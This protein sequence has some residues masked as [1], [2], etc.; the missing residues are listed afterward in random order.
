MK[1]TG[2]GCP[3]CRRENVKNGLAYSISWDSKV[4]ERGNLD[5][6]QISAKEGAHGMAG[7]GSVPGRADRISETDG[8]G[9]GGSRDAHRTSAD[10]ASEVSESSGADEK[11]ERSGPLK[12]S[13]NPRRRICGF[14]LFHEFVGY[15]NRQKQDRK[16][17]P[18]TLRV[19][20]DQPFKRAFLFG[21]IAV[22]DVAPVARVAAGMRFSFLVR[23][24]NHLLYLV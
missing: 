17:E 13:A 12:K 24:S 23:Q 22:I 7:S 5:T 14:L 15:D 6:G 3:P 1:E 9:H 16:E 4:Y 10:A 19:V 8:A 21:G 20:V 11:R 2:S 18:R